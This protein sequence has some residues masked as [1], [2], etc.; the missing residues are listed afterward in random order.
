MDCKAV[1]DEQQ[2]TY[3]KSNEKRVA[4]SSS[5]L[6]S[7][8]RREERFSAAQSCHSCLFSPQL[9]RESYVTTESLR[10]IAQCASLKVMSHVNPKWIVATQAPHIRNKIPA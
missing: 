6:E 1:S 7:A 2:G 3:S 10:T 5:M 9:G 8:I 4:P